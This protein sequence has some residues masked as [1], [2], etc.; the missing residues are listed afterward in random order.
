MTITRRAVVQKGALGAGAIAL[1]GIGAGRIAA[2]EA[3]P[4]A[5]PMAS[6]VATL[7]NAPAA[8]GI[9]SDGD[10]VVNI[11]HA[12]PDAPAVDVYVDG[13][14]T[15]KYLTFTNAS[16]WIALAAGNHQVQIVATGDDPS[17]ALIDTIITMEANTA[18]EVAAIGLLASITAGIFPADLTALGVEEARLRVIHASPDAP[19]VDLAVGGGDV[20]VA[21][22]AFPS[23]SQYLTTPA[24]SYDVEVRP[25]GTTDVA[26]ALSSVAFDAGIVYSVYV[27]GTL[28]A[29]DLAVTVVTATAEGAMTA[30]PIASPVATPAA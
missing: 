24:G 23:G 20:L 1:G 16:G 26:L 2:Q 12:A 11:V 14:K 17:T 15:I 8:L 5:V 9:G 25:T 27:V 4:D 22:L 21:N 19:A 6:P 30:T 28:A 7:G 3:T 18:Y 29:D 10:A 13:A